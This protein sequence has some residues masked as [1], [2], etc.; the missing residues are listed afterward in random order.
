MDWKRR[1]HNTFHPCCSL[2]HF[3]SKLVSNP[4]RAK[5]HSC[6][7]FFAGESL[8]MAEAA[9]T[10]ATLPDSSAALPPVTCEFI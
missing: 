3:N 10:A 2:A 9:N 8:A 7:I 5:I 6:F 4:M 1:I